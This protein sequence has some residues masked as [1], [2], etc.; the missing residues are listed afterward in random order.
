MSKV[1]WYGLD[2]ARNVVP[3]A[4][5]SHFRKTDEN[6]LQ[7]VVGYTELPEYNCRVSTVFMSIDH[8]FGTEEPLVFETMVFVGDTYRDCYC[9]RYHT[10]A[11]AEAGHKAAIAKVMTG[12][13]KC[14]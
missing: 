5:G 3:L 13:I 1:R 4:D 11:E 8:G 6:K 2:L 7:W 9:E 12:E 10:W 14:D